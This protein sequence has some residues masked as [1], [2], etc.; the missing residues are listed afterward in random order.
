M[1]AVTQLES[2]F[3]CTADPLIFHMVLVVRKGSDV[4]AKHQRPCLQAGTARISTCTEAATC[5]S[6]GQT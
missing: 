2:C 3:P 1:C 4:V 5:T 6:S